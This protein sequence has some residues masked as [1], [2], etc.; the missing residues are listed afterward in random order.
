MKR[1]SLTKAVLLLCMVCLTACTQKSEDLGDTTSGM[2]EPPVEETF[3]VLD[4]HSA[5][6][7]S[8]FT[9]DLEITR[10]P[11]DTFEGQVKEV[12][13]IIRQQYVDYDPISSKSP[14]WW[15]RE[16]NSSTELLDYIGFHKI[17]IPTWDI[18]ETKSSL[19]VNGDEEGNFDNLYLEVDYI[20]EN[21]R[22]Q[23]ICHIFTE[24]S[25][26]DSWLYGYGHYETFIQEE[27]ITPDGY[28]YIVITTYENSYGYISKD[29]FLI[30]NGI[31]YNLHLAYTAAYEQEAKELIEQCLTNY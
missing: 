28:D 11:M 29:G 25:D 16:F 15:Y 9:I 8:G 26:Q 18:K 4:M 17:I 24:F 7:D 20:I 1:Q 10:W 2:N 31:F 19:T 30:K 6:K 12:S 13:D 14:G 22:M 3:A 23:L 5:D 21:V 27:G